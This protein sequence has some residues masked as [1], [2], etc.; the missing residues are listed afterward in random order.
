[1]VFSCVFLADCGGYGDHCT[2]KGWR[3]ACM[4][5]PLRSRLATLAPSEGAASHPRHYL[6]LAKHG[7]GSG[8]RTELPEVVIGVKVCEAHPLLVRHLSE[9]GMRLPL[10]VS[11]LSCNAMHECP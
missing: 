6:E 4:R 11:G 9:L 5:F 7:M 2:I 8:S 3:P 1:M 10:E